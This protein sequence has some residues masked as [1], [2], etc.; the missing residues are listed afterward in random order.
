MLRPVHL[1]RTWLFCPGANPAAHAAALCARPDV[2]VPDLE[3]FTPP[4]LRPRGREMIVELMS[5]CRDRGIIPG[6]R[7]NPLESGGI[8][9]LDVV[10]RG[11]PQVVFLP[12]TISAAQVAALDRAIGERETL[13]G[14]AL[15]ATEIVPNVETPAG[16]IETATIARASTRVGACLIAAE[17]MAAALGAQRAPDGLE[18]AYVRARFL[19]ECVAAG[20][21]AIDAPY[22]FSDLEGAQIE[23]R[24]ARRLGYKAKS[25]VAPE[26]VAAIQS[27][28]TPDPA[29]MRR[30]QR[31]VEAFDAARARGQ[32]RVD[33]DGILVEVPS[34]LNAR[35]LLERAAEL[36][37]FGA[38]A[39]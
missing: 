7:V 38:G 18:L 24:H 32:D 37:A 14:I 27:V 3:D 21:L 26:H 28:L 15:G 39:N 1:R 35:R 8:P 6:V 17:D 22:T 13:L 33:L 16:L 29:E 9:D 34:Y 2:L 31:I 12:K 25:V 10:M 5:A 19:V 36:A 23:A 11:R 20:V 4:A 30:A